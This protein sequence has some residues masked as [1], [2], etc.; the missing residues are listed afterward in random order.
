MIA[1]LLLTQLHLIIAL[2][3]VQALMC[4]RVHIELRLRPLAERLFC[5][6]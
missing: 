4:E 5:C 6:Y 2:A 1:L 3:G